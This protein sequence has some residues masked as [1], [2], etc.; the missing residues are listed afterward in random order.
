VIQPEQGGTTALDWDH[1]REIAGKVVIANYY[2]D[3]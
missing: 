1:V 3:D 2:R